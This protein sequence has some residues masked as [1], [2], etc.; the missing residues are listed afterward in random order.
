MF[1]TTDGPFWI[2]IAIASPLGLALILPPVLMIL[3]VGEMLP[4]GT[5]MFAV[6][7]MQVCL[8]LVEMRIID[9]FV[10]LILLLHSFSL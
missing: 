3:F 5:R 8:E 6:G 1:S 7:W 9:I 4:T 10:R 2:F